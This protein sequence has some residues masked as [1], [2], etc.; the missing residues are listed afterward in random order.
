MTGTGETLDV[1]DD[2][3]R[4]GHRRKLEALVALSTEIV[5]LTGL[6]SIRAE[7]NS[8]DE[9]LEYKCMERA[10]W[11]QAYCCYYDSRNT[12]NG[13]HGPAPIVAAKYWGTKMWNKLNGLEP[14]NEYTQ[15]IRVNGNIRIHWRARRMKD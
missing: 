7:F 5:R 10:P 13:P 2:T 11:A 14:I 15:R 4:T 12:W 9:A 1:F 6:S 8:A 3:K